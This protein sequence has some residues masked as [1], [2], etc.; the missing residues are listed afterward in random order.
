MGALEICFSVSGRDNLIFKITFVNP[1][2][3]L[4]WISIICEPFDLALTSWQV[5][6]SSL[7]VRFAYEKKVDFRCLWLLMRTIM[8]RN[9]YRIGIASLRAIISECNGIFI[10]GLFKYEPVELFH[11]HR[12]ALCNRAIHL[13]QPPYLT[14]VRYIYREHFF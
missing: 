6:R 14:K 8:R 4:K 7:S 3:A 9:L 13:K 12:V 1:L 2:L 11:D 5:N 10:N